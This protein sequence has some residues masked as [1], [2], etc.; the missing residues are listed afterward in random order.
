[1]SLHKII[2]ILFFVYVAFGVKGF[3]ESAMFE[4]ISE[5]FVFIVDNSREV[6]FTVDI[7]EKG[8]FVVDIVVE[9]VSPAIS[10]SKSS[11][12]LTVALFLVT[13][14]FATVFLLFL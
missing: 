8:V 13:E 1:M 4:D 11:L 10:S 3:S 5:K 7:S 14:R 12:D 6:V 2:S 9:E